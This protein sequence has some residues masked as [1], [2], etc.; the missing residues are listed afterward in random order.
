[1]KGELHM[2]IFCF[3]SIRP[4][5]NLSYFTH[6]MKREQC[7]GI[8]LFNSTTSVGTIPWYLSIVSAWTTRIETYNPSPWLQHTNPNVME[9]ESWKKCKQRFHHYIFILDRFIFGSFRC[10]FVLV[11][12]LEWF[13]YI[14]RITSNERP[15]EL[16]PPSNERPLNEADNLMSAPLPRFQW[17]LTL[18]Q[19]ESIDRVW[20]SILC[21]HDD[22]LN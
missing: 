20:E 11:F 17:S 5:L 9:F 8:F 16:A 21:W 3:S 4:A 2:G 18:V 13:L 19:G 22:T 12:I 15:L 1:M 14:Y 6:L 7:I 10:Y